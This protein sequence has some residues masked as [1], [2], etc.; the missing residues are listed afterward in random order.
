MKMVV[1][2]EITGSSTMDV[3]V[4]ADKIH[5]KAS[6]LGSLKM[7]VDATVAGQKI[8]F[9]VGE[10]TSLIPAGESHMQYKCEG[11]TLKLHIEAE[12]VETEW[13]TLTRVK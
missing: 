8:P 4:S 11:D 5:V 6:D 9:P 1:H 2:M 10:L 7:K 13:Q 3:E 12:G